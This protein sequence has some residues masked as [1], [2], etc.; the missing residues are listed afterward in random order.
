MRRDVCCSGKTGWRGVVHAYADL[1]GLPDGCPVVTLFEGGT[2]L[3]PAP[4]LARA[5]GMDLDVR[6]KLEGLNPTG[7]FKDRGMTVAVSA[8]LGEGARLVVC[9]STGNTAASAAAFAARAGV[10][11]AV[12]VPEGK[13][14]LGKMAQACAYGARIVAIRGNFDQALTAVRAIAATGAAALVNSVNPWRIQGQMTAAFEIVDELGSAP[15][16]LVLPVGNAG[17]ITAYWKGFRE[18]WAKYKALGRNVGLPRLGGFQASGAAPI[19][20]GRPI[21]DPETV[22]TAIRIGNPASWRTAVAAAQ[23]SQGFID[24]VTDEEILR[25]YSLLAST[26]GV[27][28]EPAS[29]AAVAGMLKMAR[30]GR[31][32]AGDRVVL[33]LTGNGLKDPDTAV[34]ASRAE[35]AECDADVDSVARAMGL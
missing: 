3:V 5:A 31:L 4:G 34:A 21:P 13:I 17:N 10:A 23:E 14:A 26:E 16:W 12:V 27:F 8:A 35:I 19:V 2:P 32:R 20:R 25:A 6:L 7:S 15:D 18:Y 24:E 22:A 29:C 9:A 1:I 28:A 30:T 11:C 33:V